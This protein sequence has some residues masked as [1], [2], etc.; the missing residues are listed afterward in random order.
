MPIRTLLL[1][2]TALLP[3]ASTAHAQTLYK[4]VFVQ[5]APGRL[6]DLIALCRARLPVFDAAGDERPL[7]LR[8]SQGDHWDLLMLV[9]LG[10]F[11]DYYAP[12]RVARRE[13][14]DRETGAAGEFEQRFRQWVAWHEEVFVDGPQVSALRDAVGEAGFFHL[15][16]MMAVPGGHDELLRVREAENVYL[17]G[18]GR[19]A[20]VIFTRRDGAA[21]DL[22]TLGF[23]R[24][25][26]HFAE[27]SDV[28]GE[29]AR[30]AARA[31]GFDSP[32]AMGLH[33]RTVMATHRDTLGA[34]VR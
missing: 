18:V 11:H 13:Q 23:Y 3:A 26:R 29:K 32:E 14:A 34:I 4:A 24:D 5:A 12:P 16:A 28:P 19:P 7:I 6:S 8:H 17:R 9:P 25:L 22:L 20:N 27:S 31:A 15:E 30:I 2:L 10:S 21:Y 1:V 33:W